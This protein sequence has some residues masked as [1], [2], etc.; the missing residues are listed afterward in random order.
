[1]LDNVVVPM[2]RIY[3]VTEEYEYLR[4]SIEQFPVGG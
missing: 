4:P 1:M 2:A 3:G